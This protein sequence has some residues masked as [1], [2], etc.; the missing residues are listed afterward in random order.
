M[1]GLTPR[2]RA[3]LELL[4]QRAARA[5]P[6]PTL[7]EACRALGLRSRGSLHKQVRALEDAGLLEPA[8][9]RRRGLRLRSIERPGE[10]VELPLAGVIAAGQPLEAVTRDETVAVPA[11]LLEGRGDYVLRVRGDSMVEAGI[12]DGDYV[13]IESRAWAREGEIVVALVDRSEV[14]LKQLG[15]DGSRL[16]L[17]P[18]NRQLMP[19]A[20]DP[21][22][23]QIQGVLVAQMRRYG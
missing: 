14:T 12:L 22:R 19:L 9:G 4:I 17:I 13:V 2:Q 16:L 18:A 15:Y 11:A 10:V 1:L 20:L 21:D 3:L 7:D 23:V 8:R 5:E 6:P